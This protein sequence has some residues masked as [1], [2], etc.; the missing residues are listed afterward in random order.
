MSWQIS[1]MMLFLGSATFFL[2]IGLKGDNKQ[3]PLKLV[4]VTLAFGSLLFAVNTGNLIAQDAA[5]DIAEPTIE[6]A[7]VNT[8]DSAYDIMLWIFRLFIM[9]TILSGLF[10]VVDVLRKNKRR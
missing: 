4:F 6:T 3:L 8:L 5:T 7:L 2:F 1:L 9:I 10:T